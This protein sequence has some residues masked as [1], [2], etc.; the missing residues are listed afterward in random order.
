M[1]GH[2]IVR[3]Y[4]FFLALTLALCLPLAAM[5]ELAVVS[6]GSL[7]LRA[8]PTVGSEILGVFQEGTKL[9]ILGEDGDWYHVEVPS[10]ETGYMNR[11]YVLITARA[12]VENGDLN[13][14]LRDTPST[15]A[16][17]LG[18]YPSG[19]EVAVLGEAGYGW[20]RVDIGGAVGFMSG[21]FLRALPAVPNPQLLVTMGPVEMSPYEL[22]ISGDNT[23]VR[24]I[25]E[26]MTR[27]ATEAGLTYAIEYPLLNIPA[28]DDAIRAWIDQAIAQGRQVLSGAEAGQAAELTVDYQSYLTNGGFAGVVETGFLDS[29]LLAHP[30]ELIFTVNINVATGELITYRELFRASELPRVVG[31][32]REKLAMLPGDPAEGSAV[33]ET[34]L[35]HALITRDGI[36]VILPRGEFMA[37]AAGTQTVL[38]PYSQLEEARMLSILGISG[39]TQLSGAL[40]QGKA[41]LEHAE[42]IDASQDAPSELAATPLPQAAPEATRAPAVQPST[43]P[44]TIEAGMPATD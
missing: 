42:E 24:Q 36:A 17:I 32:L 14:N 10:G 2:D 22:L 35:S 3:R 11:A 39:D 34:W 12:E 30:T 25:G 15:D 7:R 37:S 27:S 1:R 28:A 33:D 19:T 41:L 43:L 20:Y 38:F 40:I 18:Q 26:A 5:G 29:A 8:E 6:G 23:P 31:L 13:V 21:E 4:A 44:A 16:E 9:K